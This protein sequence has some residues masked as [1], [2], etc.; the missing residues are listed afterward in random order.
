MH[1]SDPL[2]D[3]DFDLDVEDGEMPIPIG[4]VR[5]LDRFDN[6]FAELRYVVSQTH[7]AGKWAKLPDGRRTFTTNEGAVLTWCPSTKA[8]SLGGPADQSKELGAAVLDVVMLT[9]LFGNKG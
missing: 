7:L 8:W 2:E 5:I 4:R 9:A 3:D 1:D 6:T